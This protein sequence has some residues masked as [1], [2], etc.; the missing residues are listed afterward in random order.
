MIDPTQ[1]KP[2]QN[3]S[4]E[5]IDNT[6][7]HGCIL[8]PVIKLPTLKCTRCGYEWHPRKEQLPIVCPSRAC[9]SRY[10]NRKRTLKRKA[11]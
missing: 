4:S 8:T 7:A 1:K 2:P 5:G 10:W 6:H 3:I 11:A 9:K